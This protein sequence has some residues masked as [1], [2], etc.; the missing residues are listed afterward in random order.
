MSDNDRVSVCINALKWCPHSLIL[1]IRTYVLHIRTSLH[2]SAVG[3]RA[4]DRFE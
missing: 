4:T 3:E 1:P 2:L